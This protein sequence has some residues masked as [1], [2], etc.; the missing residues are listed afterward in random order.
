TEAEWEKAARGSGGNIYPWGNE[1]EASR[2]NADEG[3]QVVRATTPVGIY[4]AGT[5][6]YGLFDSAGNV[7]EWCAT[8]APNYEFKPYPYKIED[9][10]MPEYLNRTNVRVLRG[11]SWGNNQFSARCACRHRAIGLNR[12]YNGGCRVWCSPI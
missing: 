7:F 8:Q 1:F 3:E 4:A 12:N 9:E 2:L 10:W 6:G 11:G 5:N